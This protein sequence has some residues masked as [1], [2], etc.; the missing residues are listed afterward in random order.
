MEKRQLI[1]DLAEGEI[2]RDLFSVK[3]KK[4]PREYAR[5][6][7]FEMR[8]SDSTGIIPIKYWGPNDL[9]SVNRLY[10]SIEVGSVVHVRGRVGKYRE[11]LE[12]SVDQEGE[13]S[14][15]DRSDYDLEDFLPTIDKDMN[16][17]MTRLNS[18]IKQVEEP[19]LSVLLSTFFAD[20][21]FVR[22]F[23]ESP[24]S[25]QKHSNYIGGLLEHTLNVVEICSSLHSLKPDL[26]RDL[27][28]TGAIL[29]D[30]GKIDEYRV[31]TNIDMSE[32]GMLLGHIFIGARQVEEAS[33]SIEGFP[34]RLRYKLVHMILSSHGRYE[35]GSPRT[36]QFPEAVALHYADEMDAKVEQFI[37]VKKSAWTDDNWM[38]DRDLKHVYLR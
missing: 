15:V 30:I 4:P 31:T 5:G 34:P 13:I 28:I 8:L 35:Y 33:R 24:A 1:K 29:H 25:I 3:L 19:S 12:I 2:V 38:F 10:D 6:Y 27:L 22:S 18:H 36:P 14:V 26:D 11:S 9:E 16:M 23:R 20:E 37:D 21:E 7:V 17:M 32:E